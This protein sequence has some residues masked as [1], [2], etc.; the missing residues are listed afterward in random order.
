MLKQATITPACI[1]GYRN[2]KECYL[3]VSILPIIAK[4]F[5][6]LK[7]FLVSQVTNLVSG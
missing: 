7:S 5:E 3:P 2:S 6:K 1:K 4:T